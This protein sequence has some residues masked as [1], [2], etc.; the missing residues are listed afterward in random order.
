MVM[1]TAWLN[2]RVGRGR[3]AGEVSLCK[4]LGRGYS[5][6]VGVVR[7]AVGEDSGQEEGEARVMAA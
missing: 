5:S 1:V 3:R 4:G 6:G 7:I 2:G